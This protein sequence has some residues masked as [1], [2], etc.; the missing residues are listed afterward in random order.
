MTVP[1]MGF[2]LAEMERW[3]ESALTQDVLD[4]P[5]LVCLTESSSSQVE[6]AGCSH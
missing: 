2:P 6:L 1:E 4:G 5:E 3:N